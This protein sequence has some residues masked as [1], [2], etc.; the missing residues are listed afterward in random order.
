MEAAG[1]KRAVLLGV[2]EGA[3]MSI[4]FAATYPERVHALILHGGLARDTWA[5]GY[6]FR[7]AAS[8]EQLGEWLGQWRQAWGGPFGIDTW[9]PSRANDEQFSSGSPSTCALAE[10]RNQ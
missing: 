5:P 4:L 7:S 1:S 2:S 3:A 8:D 6:P 9:A 10:P